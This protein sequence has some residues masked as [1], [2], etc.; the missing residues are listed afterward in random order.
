MLY[1]TWYQK[2]E[3]MV[4]LL[5]YLDRSATGI[6][7]MFYPF[8]NKTAQEEAKQAL[9]KRIGENGN[10]VLIPRPE[11]NPAPMAT[12]A[13]SRAWRERESSRKSSS[14]STTTSL[15]VRS[16]ARP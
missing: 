12:I 8:G 4:E 3:L 11:E 6:E 7:I 10:A 2:Q 14:T 9:E 16:S 1:W 15:S 13:S 5:T